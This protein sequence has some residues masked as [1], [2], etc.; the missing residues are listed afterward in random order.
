MIFT[1]LVA[2]VV[3]S[4]CS[5]PELASN[6][7][8]GDESSRVVKLTPE[9]A[10]KAVQTEQ[11]EQFPYSATISNQD[12][13]QIVGEIL[14]KDSDEIAFRRK[15]DSKLFV[16]PVATLSAETQALVERFR[17]E[18]VDKLAAAK[19]AQAKPPTAVAAVQPPTGHRPL[20]ADYPT[21]YS[22]ALERASANG[23]DVLVIALGEKRED[24]N[25]VEMPPGG[26]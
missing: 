12:G 19:A 4:S 25:E 6:D 22:G 18:K 23:R 17:E 2:C 1:S 9:A 10:P 26:T 16:I 21:D 7:D 24:P 14:A 13:K 5:K 20:G 15:S 11:D 8:E 3:F